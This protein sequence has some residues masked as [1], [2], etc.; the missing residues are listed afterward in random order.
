MRGEEWRGLNLRVEMQLATW[1]LRIYYNYNDAVVLL[2]QSI[3]PISSFF[4]NSDRLVH[5]R[6]V[7]ANEESSWTSMCKGSKC[8]QEVKESRPLFLPLIGGVH[9]WFYGIRGGWGE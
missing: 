5:K 8:V 6:V 7:R 9:F 1:N 4:F 3:R 2:Q